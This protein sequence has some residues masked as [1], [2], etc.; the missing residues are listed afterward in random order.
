MAQE[1]KTV[2]KGISEVG[3]VRAGADESWGKTPR[4]GVEINFGGSDRDV[5]SGQSTLTE[6]S[7]RVDDEV[8]LTANLLYTDLLNM[9]E[10]FGV[11]TGSVAGDLNAGVPTAEVL[12]LAF[13][14]ALGAREDKI[15]V[16]HPGPKSTRRYEFA[17]MKVQPGVRI[18]ATAEQEQVL[19]FTLKL[20][21]PKDATKPVTI[22]DA[23]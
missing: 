11:I 16:V 9:A 5:K 15:Y 14:G 23:V 18:S 1:R 13:N 4:N 3:A 19:S 21:N 20:L 22:T 6:E 7:F 8:L 17:R 2:L 10:A 12:E